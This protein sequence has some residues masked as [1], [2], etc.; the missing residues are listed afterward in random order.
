MFQF[1]SHSF[2][3]EWNLKLIFQMK[4]WFL[5]EFEKFI[6][7]E[8]GV[9]LKIY[10]RNDG[11]NYSFLMS[12]G[13]R[14]LLFIKKLWLPIVSTTH[15]FVSILCYTSLENWFEF[16][17]WKIKLFTFEKYIFLLKYLSN[18]WTKWWKSFELIIWS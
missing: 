3:F 18:E 4:N 2:C 1:I 11:I 17:F 9:K 6:I 7:H 12:I 10:E 8:I 5:Q 16:S 15:L 13:V 14:I